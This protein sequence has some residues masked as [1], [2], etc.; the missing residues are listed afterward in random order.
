[1]DSVLFFYV[2]VL[3]LGSS[4]VY[5]I[6]TQTALLLLA[7]FVLLFSMGIILN[8]IVNVYNTYLEGVKKKEDEKK[9]RDG[10]A[11]VGSRD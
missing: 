8:G 9:K 2:V 6:T 3:M 10:E 7:W 1:V 11:N 5:A 4:A